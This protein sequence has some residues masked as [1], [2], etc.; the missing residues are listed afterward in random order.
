MNPVGV[1][2]WTAEA[3]A[4]FWRQTRER[5][6]REGIGRGPD[7]YARGTL[8]LYRSVLRG[9]ARSSHQPPDRIGGAHLDFYL[10]RLARSPCSASWLAMNRSVLRRVFD[11]QDR[12][13]LLQGCG[14]RRPR[15]L[16][17]SLTTGETAIL[18]RAATC[19]RDALLLALLYGCGLKPGETVRLIWGHF[20]PVEGLLR[21]GDRFLAVPSGLGPILRAGLERCGPESFVFAGRRPGAHLSERTVG[22]VVR[23]AAKAAG[24]N[25][26]VNA[27]M[28]RHSY[29]LHQLRAGL[30]VRALQQALG[31]RDIE[32]ALRYR[33]C[34]LP[35]EE[36]TS[37]LDA[38]AVQPPE[39]PT[40]PVGDSAPPFPVENPVRYFLA[41]LRT[42][43]R[44][45]PLR[46]R[47]G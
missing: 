19:P 41:W 23:Q 42:L 8:R 33:A 25:R 16:P 30:N 9:L 46:A 10:R 35:V 21:L 32:G 27:G 28:L 45:G 12:R 20:D 7:G 11:P 34:L 18:L 1:S 5:F 24:L 43:F 3:W 31:L 29:A 40:I 6:R 15:R 4:R 17:E 39:V 2:S 22:R 13:G 38:L 26:S 47:R 14:P 37:P 36:V 44:R